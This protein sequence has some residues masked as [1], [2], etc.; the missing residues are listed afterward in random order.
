M[1]NAVRKK[2]GKLYVFYHLQAFYDEL[3]EIREKRAHLQAL[4]DISKNALAETVQ[5]SAENVARMVRI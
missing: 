3:S 4:S 5:A 1:W 2:R